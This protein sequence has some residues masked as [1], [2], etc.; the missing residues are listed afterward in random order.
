MAI[1]LGREL[2]ASILRPGSN[3]QNVMRDSAPADYYAAAG[4]LIFA[5]WQDLMGK[6]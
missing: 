1:L 3:R 5:T 6:P 4:R 2:A